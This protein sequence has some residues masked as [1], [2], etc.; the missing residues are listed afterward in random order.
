MNRAT[1]YRHQPGHGER[2]LFSYFLSVFRK[3]ADR[4]FFYIGRTAAYFF[5]FALLFTLTAFAATESMETSE[6]SGEQ[7][8]VSSSADEASA[9]ET[10]SSVSDMYINV[11]AAWYEDSYHITNPD[12]GRS[13]YG[14]E[15]EQ[16]VASYTGW[17]YIYVKDDWTALFEMLENG[18]IDIMS[19][20]SYTDERAEHM[21]FSERP[22]GE[23]RY[24]LYVDL[25]D[26]GISPTKLSSL[27][28][29][30]I[31]VM[32]K[33]VQCTQYCDWEK[34]H[35]IQTIHVPVDSID[36]AKALFAAHK[37]DGVV[38]DGDCHLGGRGADGH[39]RYGKLGDLLRYL[40]AAPGS[41]GEAG[42]GDAVDGE[43]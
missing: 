34:E 14:Y 39:H 23:E 4:N 10:S 8:A 32:E 9:P 37:L 28:G 35:N 5:F 6:L 38:V 43:R 17:D 3:Y 27:N 13:G 22:M 41:E 19:A 15:Y 16:A 21:L 7:M 42:R 25:E 12:G 26:S 11:Q 33:T 30:R 1:P 20:I 40:E 29:K 31:A 36:E 18:R 2:G 24:Y